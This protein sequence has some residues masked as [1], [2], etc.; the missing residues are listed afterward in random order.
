ML[1]C[2]R[3][4]ASP[5]NCEKYILNIIFSPQ[6][7][8]NTRTNFYFDLQKRRI[9]V[10]YKIGREKNVRTSGE[11]NSKF[12]EEHEERYIVRLDYIEE[13]TMNTPIRFVTEYSI[14]EDLN[15]SSIKLLKQYGPEEENDFSITYPDWNVISGNI[16]E[17]SIQK[18]HL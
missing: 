17:S 18:N 2:S 11:Y 4:N 10:F 7:S 9:L 14:K 8:S 3:I 13:D 5:E 16:D 12:L 6:R 15:N 1:Y